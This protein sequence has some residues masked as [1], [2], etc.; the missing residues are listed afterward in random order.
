MEKTKRDLTVCAGGLNCPNDVEHIVELAGLIEDEIGLCEEHY[1]ETMEGYWRMKDEY[2]KLV[3]GGVHKK[4][5][6]KI[7]CRRVA[8]G[9]FGKKADS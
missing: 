9:E 1:T 5:A 4:I 3:S 6:N 7:M 8:A 2:Q